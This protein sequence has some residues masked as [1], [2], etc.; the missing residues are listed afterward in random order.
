MA[1]RRL[2]LSF[3]PSFLPDQTLY[4]WVATFHEQSGNA[5][6]EETLIRLFGSDKAGHQFHIPSHLDA[7]CVV[8]QLCLGNVEQIVSQA[9]ILPAYLNF[10]PTSI[11]TDALQRVSGNMT[12]GVAQM[13]R[14]ASSWLYG[15]PPRRVCHLCAEEDYFNFGTAYWHRSHQL[16][17]YLVCTQHETKLHSTRMDSHDKRRRG[18]LTPTLD[19]HNTCAKASDSSHSK[20]ELRQLMRLSVLAMEMGSRPLPCCYSRA[21]MRRTCV[22]ALQSRNLFREDAT[23]CILQAGRDYTDHFRIVAGIPELACVLSQRSTR[24]LWCLLS[25]TQLPDHPLE[26][27][28]LIDWLFGDW[29]TFIREYRKHLA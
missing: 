22:S 4:S 20:E 29:D 19:L 7:F 26:Y 3:I 27:L 14:M 2:P 28:L 11:A 25:N 12:A 6:E 23:D 5:S 24:P 10:R 17:G 13:L 9:T 8:T 18:F 15:S 21:T 1:T 16:P